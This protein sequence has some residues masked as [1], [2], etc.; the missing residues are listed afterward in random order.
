VV[1]QDWALV[2]QDKAVLPAATR[3]VVAGGMVGSRVGVPGGIESR[4][5]INRK[6]TNRLNFSHVDRVMRRI[7]SS[8]RYHILVLHTSLRWLDHPASSSGP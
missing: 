4:K 1:C 5:T 8:G 2:R 3:V 7:Q 6:L